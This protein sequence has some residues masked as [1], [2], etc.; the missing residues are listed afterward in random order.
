MQMPCLN[1]EAFAKS[2]SKLGVDIRLGE[3][4]SSL[5]LYTDC[6]RINFG[7]PLEG[8]AKRELDR[9]IELIECHS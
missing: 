7:Y 8:Q 1:P 6:L 3:L 4:F 2:I 5:E 9:V